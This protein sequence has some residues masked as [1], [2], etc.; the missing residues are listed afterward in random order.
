MHK[1]GKIISIFVLAAIVVFSG[2]ALYQASSSPK[3]DTQVKTFT[4]YADLS[5]YVNNNIAKSQSSDY[6]IT[7]FYSDK[8]STMAAQGTSSISTEV[9][10]ASSY[11]DTNIQVQ[12]VDEADIV[13]TDGSYLYIVSGDTIYIVQAQPASDAQVVSKI[14]LNNT[15]NSDIYVDGNRLV[16]LENQFTPYVFLPLST[17]GTYSN[18]SGG[19]TSEPAVP[20][21]SVV[22]SDVAKDI[23]VMPPIWGGYSDMMSV[24]IY[25][26]S[27]KSSPVLVRDIDMNGTFT[28]SRMIGDV[29]YLVS[30]EPAQP[31]YNSTVVLP[32]IFDNGTPIAINADQV[33]YADVPAS[34]YDFVTVLAIDVSNDSSTPTSDTFLASASSTMYVAQ[35]NMYLTVPYYSVEPMVLGGLTSTGSSMDETL[36]YRVSLDGTNV[37]LEAQGSVPGSVLDQYSMDEYNGDFRIATTEWT[38]NGT[39]ND[40]FVLDQNLSIIG[41][42]QGIASGESIYSALFMG[43]RCYLV[44]YQQ[45]DPFYVIDLSNP[46]NPQV[47]GYLNVTGVSNYLYPYD[48]N[49]VIGI[50]DDNG[51][52]QLSLFDVTNV[53]APQLIANY[54][55]QATWSYTEASYDHKA[56]LFD[57]SRS[58]LVLPVSMEMIGQEWVNWQGAFVFN[59]TKSSGFVLEGTITHMADVTQGGGESY[60][61]RALYIG[62]VLYTISDDLVKL[63][64]LNT[65]TELNEVPLS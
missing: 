17:N 36:I 19:T 48:Q 12:G 59:V 43:D 3:I 64:D 50:G 9:P 21:S 63:T 51:N 45:V 47:L 60:V 61:D 6:P 5:S 44:T 62:N 54:T 1:K 34:Y 14:M 2:V 35:D 4:S 26:I 25:D 49:T 65:M 10:T 37:T 22:S 13:K 38:Q 32:M 41:S 58:L 28:G 23:G 15:Y 42:L 27:N 39:I 29:V 20:A 53:S 57:A 46:T 7:Q 52:V 8:A 16:V 31:Y 33:S 30:N 18:S 55:F 56:F 24:S 40:V 11:S